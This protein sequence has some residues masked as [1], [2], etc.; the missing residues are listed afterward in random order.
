MQ[1]D[2]WLFTVTWDQLAVLVARRTSH[3]FRMRDEALTIWISVDRSPFVR[4]AHSTEAVEL[5]PGRCR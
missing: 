1:Q 3:S 4:H 5:G 2:G